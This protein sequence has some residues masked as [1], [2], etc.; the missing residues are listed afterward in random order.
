MCVFDL[1]DL[2]RL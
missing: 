2:K 1:L